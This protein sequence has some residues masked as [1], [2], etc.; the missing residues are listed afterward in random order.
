MKRSFL[1]GMLVPLLLLLA[2][3][4]VAQ[5]N[6][7]ADMATKKK[8]IRWGVMAGL[9]VADFSLQGTKFELENKPGWQVG[10]MASIALGKRWTLD[11]QFLYVRH[12]L[13]LKQPA[14]PQTGDLTSS[15]IDVPIGVGYKLFG[16]LRLFAGPVFTLMNETDGDF[17]GIELDSSGLRTTLSYMVGAEVRLFNRL[18]VDVRYNGAFKQK[19]DVMLFDGEGGF[20]K[21]RTQLFSL[22]VG[23]YF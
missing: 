21:A 23:Y 20:G 2:Q 11:P 8:P 18:R 7:M 22:N 19:D 12:K 1:Y 15:S 9:N 5:I 4:G 17:R 13:D 10:M 16:P 6:Y 3:S 14:Y